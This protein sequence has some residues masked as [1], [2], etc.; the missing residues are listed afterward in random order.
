MVIR[1][2]AAQKRMLRIQDVGRTGMSCLSVLRVY[3][4]INDRQDIPVLPT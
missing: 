4:L 2:I 3:F 1:S